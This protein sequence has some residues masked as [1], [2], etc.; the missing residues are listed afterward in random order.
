MSHKNML[1][2]T[3]NAASILGVSTATVRNWIKSSLL[4]VSDIQDSYLDRTEV[5]L[6]KKRISEKKISKLTGRANKSKATTH[7]I[8]VEY[9]SDPNSVHPI[10]AIVKHASK[11]KIPLGKVL[12]IIAL[13]WLSRKGLTTKPTLEQLR[14]G[15]FE[16]SHCRISQEMQLWN[17]ELPVQSPE[18]D[19]S[20]LLDCL[21]P[22]ENDILGLLYQS[23]QSEGKK[24]R[25]GSYYTPYKIVQGIVND[26]VKPHHKALDPCC[27]T[28]QFL[29]EFAERIQ[30]P[31]QIYGFDVDRIAVHIARL[32]LLVRFREYDFEPR[33]FCQDM[34]LS[35]QVK[36]L[37]QEVDGFEIIATNPPWGYHFS[38]K[39]KKKLRSLYPSLRSMESYS[40]FLIRCIELL[41]T[42]GILSFILPESILQVGIHQDIRREILKKTQIR[43]I[44]CLGSAFKNVFTPAI[45]LD[46]EKGTG[47]TES[48]VR[49]SSEGKE[50]ECTPS[51]W[52]K[53]EACRFTVYTD[54]FSN[55]IINK[56]Y[57]TEFVTLKENADW[58]LGIVTG[59]NI[60]YLKKSPEV[61]FT[62]IYAGKDVHRYKLS[63]ATNYIDF[64]PENF[65]QVAPL[66]RYFAPEKLIYRFVCNKLVMAYDA[67][68]SLTLNSANILIPRIPDYPIKV[69]LALF[70][71]SLYQFLYQKKFSG[72]KVLRSYLEAL[73]LPLLATSQEKEIVKKVEAVLHESGDIPGLDSYIFSL[74]SLTP[75][76]EQYII[77][78]I[79]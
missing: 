31:D 79:K 54:D 46:L 58:A 19:Y 71:S 47:T 59:N 62:H 44:N 17:R 52:R 68:Q 70:N 4:T 65:Q 45:R 51:L 33:V 23:L 28:G 30:K 13:N 9:L 74:F 53:E 78:N 26:F 3:K 14:N 48:N 18:K 6:L 36:R 20:F 1:I 77:E 11:E 32:N 7:F 56:I 41:K 57:S 8:P 21:L 38:G 49:I 72:V 60:H 64:K 25:N 5:E 75:Q 43:Q 34:L 73:P 29:L 16:I 2:D 24:S 15:K 69:I 22:E 50:Y 10:R 67:Q 63:P 12:F 42:E 66:D 27:G 40:F 39:Q 55:G 35:G 61:G 76:E 37:L